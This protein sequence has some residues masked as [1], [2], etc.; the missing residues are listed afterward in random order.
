MRIVVIS[1]FGNDTVPEGVTIDFEHPGLPLEHYAA[2]LAMIERELTA[3]YH[4]AYVPDMQCGVLPKG[5]K[6]LW[7]DS[8]HPN[9]AGNRIVADTILPELRKVLESGAPEPAEKP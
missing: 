8:N 9:S 6:D 5:R 4:C 3:K 1:C 7:S 2:G